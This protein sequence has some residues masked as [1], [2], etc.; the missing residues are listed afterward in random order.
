MSTSRSASTEPTSTQN[1]QEPTVKKVKW[2]DKNVQV[3]DDEWADV[4][5]EGQEQGQEQDQQ[6]GREEGQAEPGEEPEEE[7]ESDKSKAK[8]PTKK[9]KAPST[10]NDDRLKTS[11][12]SLLRR[13]RRECHLLVRASSGV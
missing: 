6:G 2:A 13:Y 8:K 3:A 12:G 11:P 1:A 10:D 5:E 4:S 7:L 9:S